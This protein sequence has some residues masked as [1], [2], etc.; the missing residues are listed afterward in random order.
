MNVRSNSPVP[1]PPIAAIGLAACLISM[2]APSSQA[3]LSSR[4]S[5]LPPSLIERMMQAS[6]YQLTGPVTRRG[7]VYLADVLGREDDPERLVI[8][9]HDGR[10]LQRYPGNP[11]IRRQAAIPDD[12]TVSFASFTCRPLGAFT[13][14]I[15][16]NKNLGCSLSKRT[17]SR[18]AILVNMTMPS[19]AIPAMR[20]SSALPPPGGR[21]TSIRRPSA[22]KLMRA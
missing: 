2:G 6:G 4:H 7:P 9:A 21:R 14:R 12:G 1:R 16:E 20:P 17:P 13:D 22:F 10:L 3:Q 5:A 8:D 18:S 15:F 11:A 19:N